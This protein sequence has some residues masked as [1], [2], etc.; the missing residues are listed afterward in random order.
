M[1]SDGQGIRRTAPAAGTS[2][3]LA[4]AAGGKRVGTN[5]NYDATRDV[6]ADDFWIVAEEIVR[7]A[8]FEQYIRE[9]RARHA[10]PIM[11]TQETELE[12]YLLDHDSERKKEEIAGSFPSSYPYSKTSTCQ[13]CITDDLQLYKFHA[14][15]KAT[16]RDRRFLDA[17]KAEIARQ[18]AARVIPRDD[19]A[20]TE[21]CF[22]EIS[23]NS[24]NC[25]TCA[26]C[27]M[28]F[29]ENGENQVVNGEIR[30]NL[31]FSCKRTITKYQLWCMVQRENK[32]ALFVRFRAY[33]EG[34]R[35][36]AMATIDRRMAE[37]M[38]VRRTEL[39]T[40]V[41]RLAETKRQSET[42]AR[43]RT[44]AEQE[45]NRDVDLEFNRMR[46]PHQ[47]WVQMKA[48]YDRLTANGN[49]PFYEHVH[50][51]PIGVSCVFCP[52]CAVPF[53]ILAPS[54]FCQNMKFGQ[55]GLAHICV[56]GGRK[57]YI[58]V[59]GDSFC[60]ICVIIIIIVCS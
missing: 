26:S 37:L 52:C 3:V 28:D 60:I 55:A 56:T 22:T 25:Y 47:R 54:D 46:E 34:R 9:V 48:T 24:D 27:W 21:R 5:V 31:H 32:P 33:V 58:P 7:R 10:G 29:A 53:G 59:A 44:Q 57:H 45:L 18:Q 2:A 38:S 50:T 49:T 12:A 8:H 14:H 16:E 4:G 17:R 36:P 20:S 6:G 42:I 39:E 43:L 35:A 15:E 51:E 41:A 23:T 1:V 19:T 13:T 30:C 11:K 40:T